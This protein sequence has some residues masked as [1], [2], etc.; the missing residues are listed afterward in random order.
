MKKQ[1]LFAIVAISLT[2]CGR[3]IETQNLPDRSDAPVQA[4]PINITI[5]PPAVTVGGDTINVNVG[6]DTIDNSNSTVANGGSS[7]S[8]SQGGAG[9]SSSSN[10]SSQGGSSSAT[11]GSSSATG[12]NNSNNISSGNSSAT[13]TGGT[14]G[15]ASAGNATSNANN[16]G[17]SN[18]TNTSTNS[19]SASNQAN[20][21]TNNSADNSSNVSGS[22]NSNNSNSNSNTNTSQSSA[23]VD[24][25]IDYDFNLELGGGEDYFKKAKKDKTKAPKK[26]ED[27]HPDLN[28]LCHVY[29]FTGRSTL[30]NDLATAPHLGSFYMDKWDITSRDYN[31]GFPKLPAS[32]QYLR[33]YYAVRCFAKLKVTTGGTHTF[34]ITSDDGMRVLL[35]NAVV[36]SDDGLH[37]PRTQASTAIL[38]SGLY[39]LEVQW[40]QGPRTQIAAELKWATPSNSTLRYIEASDMQKAKKLC[41]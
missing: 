16:S 11:G 8:T 31:Q 20:N 18:S 39:D 10:S 37:A 21:S 2:G 23:E 36:L 1:L 3:Y 25:E 40:F 26:C 34:S 9:G 22:G 15:G 32:L 12:G 35:N 14:G 17:S 41:K 30:A 28:M 4:Q 6:G 13:G 19:G 27:P 24:Q 7:S 38:Y 29:D 5:Q 33:E